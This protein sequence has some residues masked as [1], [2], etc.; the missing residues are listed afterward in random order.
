MINDRAI[1]QAFSDLRANSGGVRE[2]YF[3]LLYLE[4]DI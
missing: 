2:D 1:D 3:G 4:R